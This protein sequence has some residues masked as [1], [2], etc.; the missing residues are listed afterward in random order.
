MEKYTKKECMELAQ[1]TA[2]E[3]VITEEG[4]MLPN[5]HTAETLIEATKVIYEYLNS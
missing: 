3:S 4:R 1:R 2:Q 5:Q